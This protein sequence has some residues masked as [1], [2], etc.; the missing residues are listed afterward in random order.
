MVGKKKLHDLEFESMH[1]YFEY[2]LNSKTNGAHSQVKEL[3]KDLSNEQ[4]VEFCKWLDNA[5]YDAKTQLE[6][7][8][9]IVEFLCGTL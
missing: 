8:L 6:W 1:E 2:I 7:H 3:V 9:Y 4:K 5:G